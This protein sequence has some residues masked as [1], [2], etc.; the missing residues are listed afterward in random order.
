V[1]RA[2]DFESA[3][4]GSIPPGAT[5][6]PATHIR[7]PLLVYDGDCSFC[8]ASAGW[9]AARWSGAERAVAWQELGADALDG[10]GIGAGE[11]RRA[12]WWIDGAG[13]RSR[14][15]VAIARALRSAHGRPALLGTVLLVPPFRWLAAG[16]Y[17]LVARWRHRM[18]GSSPACRS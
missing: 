1:D 17:R 14:G 9:I 18:P 4:G 11:A 6:S 3:R 15:H 16:G 10:L 5:P 2:A 13:G 7:P 8:T 12:A